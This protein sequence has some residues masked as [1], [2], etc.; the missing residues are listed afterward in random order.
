MLQ[1][2][3]VQVN[4]GMGVEDLALI[5]NDPDYRVFPNMS[6]NLNQLSFN[7][8]DPLAS[9][10]N[11]RMAV[12]HAINRADIALI[13]AGDWAQPVTDGSLWGWATE[14]RVNDLP[15][16]PF[17]L[18]KARE[19]LEKSPYN[20]ET[21][22]IATAITTNITASQVVQ[23]Q[24]SLIGI[25]VFVN[26]F[27]TPGFNA[28]ITPGNKPAHMSLMVASFML[29]AGSARNVFYPGTNGNRAQLNDP[30]VNHILETAPTTGNVA[31]RRALYEQLQRHLAED[32]PML[33]LFWRLQGY[34]TRSN[35][36]GIIFS[37]I[38]TEIN[39]RNIYMTV[40]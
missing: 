18:D 10:Y 22:E 28:Y 40:D 30:V 6:N 31:E 37:A 34:A 9:D 33:N 39:F 13:A 14:F 25:D 12:A 1:N 36:G 11:F 27:D 8:M 38:P 7:M 15:V 16:I 5:M 20:G 32:P 3:E 17:D 19:Y 21:I 35:V 4:F 23:E 29:H 26:T 24:L 2:N